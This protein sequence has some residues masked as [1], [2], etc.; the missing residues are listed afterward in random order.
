M[1]KHTPYRVQV[2]AF[3]GKSTAITFNFIGILFFSMNFSFS[4]KI[5]AIERNHIEIRKLKT[6]FTV[7]HSRSNAY[8]W[9]WKNWCTLSI[10]VAV[11]SFWWAHLPGDSFIAFIETDLWKSFDGKGTHY[12]CFANTVSV[13]KKDGAI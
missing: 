5:F 11:R 6:G 3:L 4:F 10:P 13:K 2:C 8:D 7:I 1:C 9:N 12:V